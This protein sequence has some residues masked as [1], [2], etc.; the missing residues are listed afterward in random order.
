MRHC[1]QQDPG[2]PGAICNREA[3]H[4]GNHESDGYIWAQSRSD[5]IADLRAKLAAAER[6]LEKER[7]LHQLDHSLADQWQAKAE[8]AETILAGM[9]VPFSVREGLTSPKEWKERSEKFIAD[10]QARAEAAEQR[11][12]GLREA[13]TRLEKY[14]DGQLVLQGEE[15]IQAIGAWKVIW[16]LRAALAVPPAAAKDSWDL[17]V[18]VLRR[19]SACGRDEPEHAP[20]CDRAPWRAALKGSP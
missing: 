10:L 3:G 6:E 2:G 12:R 20:Q 16:D 14:W 17:V 19:C 15:E 18:G 7:H 9:F 5:E 8:A 11:E 4:L 13:L 1:N